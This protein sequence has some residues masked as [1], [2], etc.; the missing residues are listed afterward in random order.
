M[1]LP[2][3]VSFN[4]ANMASEAR[5]EIDKIEDQVQLKYE[6]PPQGFIG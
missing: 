6:L 5:A 1:S 3:G 4:G 2:G